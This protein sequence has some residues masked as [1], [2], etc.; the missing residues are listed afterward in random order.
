MGGGN[1][2][3]N[4]TPFGTN[5]AGKVANLNADRVDDLHA[6]EIVAA[7]RTSGQWWAPTAL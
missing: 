7:P 3:A 5:A 6:D 2:N 4:A 1:P